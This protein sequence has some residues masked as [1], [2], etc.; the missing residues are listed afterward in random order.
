M[1]RRLPASDRSISDKAMTIPAS[2]I[3][4]GARWIKW[5]ISLNSAT[6]EHPEQSE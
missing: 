6:P 4:S 3:L 2:G 5:L 1:I